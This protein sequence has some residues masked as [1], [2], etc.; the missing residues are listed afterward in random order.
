MCYQVKGYPHYVLITPN[1]RIK[2]TWGGYGK[3]SLKQRLKKELN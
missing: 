1:G 2:A 3:G